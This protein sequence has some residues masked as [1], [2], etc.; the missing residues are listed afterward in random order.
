M[1]LKCR[2]KVRYRAKKIKDKKKYL[3]LSFCGNK[4]VE[5]KIKSYKKIRKV[6]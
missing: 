5:A 3:R 6:L 4:V 1:P 2:G